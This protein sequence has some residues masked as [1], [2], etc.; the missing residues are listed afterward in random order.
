MA[1]AALPLPRL[2]RRDAAAREQLDSVARGARPLVLARD[3]AVALSTS[4]GLTALV[5]GGVVVRGSVLRVAGEPGA[6][7]TTV[8]F[9]LA[10]AFTAMGEWAAAVDCDGTTVGALAAHEAGVALERFAVVRRVPPTRWATVVAALLDGVS[11]V[12]AEVPRGVGLGDARRLVARAR[13][14]ES[15]LVAYE[16][17]VRWP[18]E[19]QFAV[20]AETS[21]WDGLGADAGFLAARRLQ[22]RVEGRGAATRTRTGELARAV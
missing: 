12:V 13:E 9:E 8:A 5:P 4:S 22:V 15:V 20:Y 6:G 17:W 14:R 3:R 10:A 19:A 11:L 21:E 1:P 7:A 16:T 2:P 18:A